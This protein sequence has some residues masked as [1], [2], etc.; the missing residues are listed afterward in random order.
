MIAQLPGLTFVYGVKK[1]WSSSRPFL[2][3]KYL[4]L[5]EAF[6]TKKWGTLV[7]V[8]NVQGRGVIKK[9]KKRSQVSEDMI[10]KTA[11]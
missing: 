11:K 4:R 8:Q 1:L 9:T 5:R 7:P 3:Y 6:Q 2:K 10:S